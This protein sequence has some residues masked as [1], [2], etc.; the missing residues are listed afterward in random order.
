MTKVQFGLFALALLMSGRAT[1][2]DNGII[3]EF[4]GVLQY[5]FMGL[6]ILMV[7][8][9]YGLFRQVISQKNAPQEKIKMA[10]FF[11]TMA[12]LFLVGAGFLEFGSS[13]LASYN[14]RRP[15][16]IVVNVSPWNAEHSKRFGE[17]SI[18][19]G[20][21][22]KILKDNMLSLQVTDNAEITI[23]IYKL[24]NTLRELQSQV[25]NMITVKG[26]TN[27]EA[28]PGEF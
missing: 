6:S 7:F 20:M 10:K 9:G 21:K 5:G 2:D 16:N 25:N 12:F 8:L 14:D 17:L 27:D 3:S 22:K 26:K 24:I 15:V 1:A 4:A 23:E 13:F 11:L 19:K 28:G 18:R